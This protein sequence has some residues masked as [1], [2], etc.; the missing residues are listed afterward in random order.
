MIDRT[1]LISCLFE[2]RAVPCYAQYFIFLE[3]TITTPAGPVPLD[4]INADFIF[5]MDIT[6]LTLATH[7]QM[8]R[9]FIG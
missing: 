2:A 7:F 4:M 6:R 1:A 5:V 9:E 8:V 3:T